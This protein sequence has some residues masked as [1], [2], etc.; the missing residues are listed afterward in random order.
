MRKILLEKGTEYAKGNG[1]P[2]QKNKSRI[3]RLREIQK[4]VQQAIK[5]EKTTEKSKKRVIQNIDHDD[6]KKLSAIDR[7]HKIQFK[8]LIRERDALKTNKKSLEQQVSSQEKT[9]REQ[10]ETV[11]KLTHVIRDHKKQLKRTFDS[12]KILQLVEPTLRKSKNP[13][14]LFRN[15]LEYKKQKKLYNYEVKTIEKS[16]FTL[17]TWHEAFAIG[18]TGDATG[19]YKIDYLTIFDRCMQVGEK[20]VRMYYLADIPAELSP[21]IQ[22]KLLASQLPFTLSVFVKPTP[23]NDLLKKSRQRISVLEAQ[24]Y[25]RERKGL[26]RDPQI[27]RNIEETKTFADDLVYEREKGLEYA[28]YCEL[29]ADTREA[30]DVLHKEFI[31]LAESMEVVFNTYSYGQ[32][33]AFK[34]LMP[35]GEDNIKENRIIQ[36]SGGS[37]LMPFVAKPL[38]NPEG[39]F[40]GTNVYHNSLVFLNPFTTEIDENNN[41]NI[42]GVSGAGKSVTSKILA[43][44]MYM[45]GTQIIII[46]PEGEYV[47]LAR[48]FGGEVIQFSRDNGI[49]PFSLA[50][51]E[52]NQI[53][54]H[55]TMLKTFFKF[56]LPQEKYEGAKLDKIMVDLYKKYPKEKPTFKKFLT[57]IKKTNMYEDLAVLNGGSLKG[58]FNTERDLELT[59]DFIVFDLSALGENEI[60]PPAMYL[61]TSLIW[62]LVNTIGTRQRMLFIDEAHTLLKDDDVARDYQKL[63]KQARKRNLGVVS[64]TQDVEDFLNHSLGKAIINNS[65]TK[66]LLKQSY[67]ALGLMENIFPMTDEEK[68]SMGSLRKGEVVIFRENDHVA[69]YIKVLPSE[70]ELV[71]TDH[72]KSKQGSKGN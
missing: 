52:P 39:I 8:M 19:K 61:L 68:K 64:I 15:Y 70:M 16:S 33:D 63:V 38:Y 7:L 9:I 17:N 60:K 45:Q 58:V 41:I 6:K 29:E 36:S 48:K 34:N 54:D 56:F 2:G 44:R 43:S 13:I 66:I 22:F 5:E 23:N 40:I 37:Y 20:W 1:A 35:F 14:K 49:N 59:N 62:Q 69:A 42:F 65:A 26:T 4:E 71:F 55:V 30:L 18:T 28:L 11:E 3:E 57:A 25:Q 53:L 67:A 32:K 50:S 10:K 12:S 47:K 31:N 27:D 21:Y 24:Q 46:D 51:N 72:E